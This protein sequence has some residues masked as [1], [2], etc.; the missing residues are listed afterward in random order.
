MG[1]GCEG[2]VVR[3]RSAFRAREWAAQHRSS[4]GPGTAAGPL[5]HIRR[6]HGASSCGATSLA[7]L[8]S[9]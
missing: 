2:V 3:D 5:G 1:V 7:C 9:L 4:A 6:A 8:L